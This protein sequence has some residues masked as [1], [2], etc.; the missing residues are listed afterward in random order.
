MAEEKV[1]SV[2]QFFP[3]VNLANLDLTASLKKGDKIRIKGSGADF[4]QTV[5]WL[6]ANVTNVSEAGPGSASIKAKD[7]CSPGDEVFRLS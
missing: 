3:F 4:E 1:G 7:R 5:D 6:Q 2:L